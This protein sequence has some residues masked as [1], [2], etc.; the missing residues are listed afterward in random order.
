[1]AQAKKQQLQTIP[2]QQFALPLPPGYSPKPQPHLPSAIRH[3][4]SAICHLLAHFSR[5]LL[6]FG[7]RRC[8]YRSR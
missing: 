8:L 7:D 5:H 2:A 6:L 1:M 3:P 4:P